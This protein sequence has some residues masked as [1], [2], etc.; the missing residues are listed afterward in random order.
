MEVAFL[1]NGLN[2]S[3]HSAVSWQLRTV[4]EIY[5][6]ILKCLIPIKDRFMKS[7]WWE[8]TV[9]CS[10]YG[11]QS[12]EVDLY[13]VE[14]LLL[15]LNGQV[16]IIFTFELWLDLSYHWR[17]RIFLQFSITE[18]LD[19]AIRGSNPN[20]VACWILNH[21]YNWFIYLEQLLLIWVSYFW[22]KYLAVFSCCKQNFLVF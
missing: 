21:T 12:Y 19:R 3:F 5:E 2:H 7:H 6:H 20:V 11:I 9:C 10:L 8:H 13:Q 16:Y 17:I 15:T 18:A 14:I 22:L 1:L 4:R